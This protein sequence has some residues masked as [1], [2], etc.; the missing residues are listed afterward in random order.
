MYKFLTGKTDPENR[1]LWLPLW[2][3]LRDTAEIMELLVREWLPDST[4]RSA[5]MD[6]EALGK[7]F[8]QRFP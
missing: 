2:I 6:E 1:S 4:K 8:H 5:G 7:R 3:H